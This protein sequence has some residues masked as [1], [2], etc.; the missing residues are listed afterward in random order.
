[1]A[2]LNRQVSAKKVDDAT[3]KELGQ[4]L[5]DVAQ[6]FGDGNYAAA[7]TRLNALAGQLGNR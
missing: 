1:M 4:M 5:R 7:N 2:R 3:N 6:K